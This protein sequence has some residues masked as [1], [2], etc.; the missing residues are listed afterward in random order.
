MGINNL[1]T[2][3]LV[4]SFSKIIVKQW[5]QVWASKWRPVQNPLGTQGRWWLHLVESHSLECET[6]VLR[7]RLAW[8]SEWA[9]HLA[10]RARG[11]LCR[12]EGQQEWKGG[13]VVTGDGS[14]KPGSITCLLG[15]PETK[16]R[17][18][19]AKPVGKRGLAV[20]HWMKGSRRWSWTL[21]IIWPH[22]FP[23]QSI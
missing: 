13:E 15:A 4:C 10:G 18:P 22:F 20:S 23:S 8:A 12:E 2:L 16:E 1:K 3:V 6:H 7:V 19:R 21:T 14:H 5:E 9:G 17:N 11:L